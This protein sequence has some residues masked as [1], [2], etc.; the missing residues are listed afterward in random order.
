MSTLHVSDIQ[1]NVSLISR[2]PNFSIS[3]F[4]N[5]TLMTAQVELVGEKASLPYIFITEVVLST[6]ELNR[7]K[8]LDRCR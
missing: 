2:F 4:I 1:W 8:V 6:G 5:V 3:C 7:L